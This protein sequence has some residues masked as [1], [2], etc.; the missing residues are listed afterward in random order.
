MNTHDNT[1]EM[2]LNSDHAR[3]F[4]ASGIPV[5][6]IPQSVYETIAAELI[7]RID[8]RR[9]YEVKVERDNGTFGWEY[10]ITFCVNY[11]T[12]CRPDGDALA[13]REVAPIWAEFHVWFS[14]EGDDLQNDFDAEKLRDH[15]IPYNKPFTTTGV[16]TG[17]Q[18]VSHP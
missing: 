10:S 13:I 7:D 14:D 6:R 5:I 18:R 2:D 17:T 3:R 9:N 12:D 15:G 16:R 1:L 8:G 11:D 4:T